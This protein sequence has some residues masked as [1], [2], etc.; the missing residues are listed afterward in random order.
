MLSGLGQTASNAQTQSAADTA[1]QTQTVTQLSNLCRTL[2]LPL[3]GVHDA[4]DHLLGVVTPKRS[5][6][7]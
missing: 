2:E 1:V 7:A 4:A 6:A 5:K 3:T